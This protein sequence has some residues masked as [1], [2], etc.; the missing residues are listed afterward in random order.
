M[1][2]SKLPR[3][4]RVV[5]LKC[6]SA[7]RVPSRPSPRPDFVLIS[8]RDLYRAKWPGTPAIYPIAL[9]RQAI[10]ARGPTSPLGRYL[11]ESK[12]SA[13]RFAP[14]PDHFCLFRGTDNKQATCRLHTR[15][16]P[17]ALRLR[18]DPR[19]GASPRRLAPVIVGC[20]D[21]PYS[22]TPDPLGS[23]TFCSL[24]ESSRSGP[25]TYGL[26]ACERSEL[27][28]LIWLGDAGPEPVRTCTEVR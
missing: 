8:A 24:A 18:P 19:L 5:F 1:G 9:L 28:R 27:S 10:W 2:L 4:R 23:P 16:C 17:L 3:I 15:L 6:A 11:V 7:L 12:P 13:C 25:L 20:S 26:G 21:R 22:R 14:S